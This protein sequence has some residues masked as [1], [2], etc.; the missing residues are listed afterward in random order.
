[1][2]YKL[3]SNGDS[4]LRKSKKNINQYFYLSPLFIGIF[5]FLMIF[6]A[7]SEGIKYL[8]I[9]LTVVMVVFNIG[10]L[11]K[12]LRTVNNTVSNITIANDKLIIKTFKILN[13]KSQQLVFDI[14]KVKIK[15]ETIMFTLKEKEEG[16]KIILHNGNFFYLVW[17]HFT[18]ELKDLLLKDFKS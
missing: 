17:S 7:R 9:F 11:L 10:G 1:M 14:N 12:C 6:S 15:N 2:E 3:N 18:P 13:Y 5:S 4:Y 8:G 16:C